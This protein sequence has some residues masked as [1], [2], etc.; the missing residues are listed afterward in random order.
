MIFIDCEQGSEEWHAARCGVVTAS[1]VRE[2]LEVAF[3]G[4]PNEKPSAK[5]EL[6]AAQVAM[7]RVSK[8]PCGDIFNSWQMKQGQEREPMARM[9]Y[10]AETGNL[11]SESG[12]VLTDDRLFGYSTDGFIND[13]GMIEIKCLA[14]AVVV[15]D[16]LLTEDLSEYIHQIQTGLWITGRKWCDFVMYVPELEAAGNHLFIKRVYRDE[17]FIEDME[18]GLVKFERS[19]SANEA[20]FR[21]KK[22]A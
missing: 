7:E 18:I 1:K 19:V 6:Y 3:K 8:K 16:M 12:V 9:A 15:R 14:S 4:K 17:A 13:D 11:A 21:L 20:I 2:A 22:A 10:E 5:A